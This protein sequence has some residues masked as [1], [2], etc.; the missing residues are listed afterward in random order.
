[1]NQQT[2]KNQLEEIDQKSRIANSL[3]TILYMDIFYDEV[4]E[5]RR[6][7]LNRKDLLRQ[8]SRNLYLGIAKREVK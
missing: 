8:P 4:R 6:Y 7:N 2:L 1:M 3:D 5:N